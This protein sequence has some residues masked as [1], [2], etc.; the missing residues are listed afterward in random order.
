MRFYNSQIRLFAG[1]D[2][3]AR[4]MH[5][6][7]LAHDGYVVFEKNLPFHFESLLQA[8]APSCD[9]IVIGVERIHQGQYTR[10]CPAPCSG[11]HGNPV[12]TRAGVT[13]PRPT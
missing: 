10:G 7:I 8:I 1:I 9:E 13:W 12:N 11:P 3:H 5:L 6:C 2:L 4:T